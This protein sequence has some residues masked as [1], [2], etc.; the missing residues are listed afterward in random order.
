MFD[1]AHNGLRGEKQF[2]KGERERIANNSSE[3]L[4]PKTVPNT[5]LKRNAKQCSTIPMLV[6]K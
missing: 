2:E 6:K 3:S 5:K 1:N 4:T